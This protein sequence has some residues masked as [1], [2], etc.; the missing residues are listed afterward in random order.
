VILK[1][2]SHADDTNTIIIIFYVKVGLYFVATTVPLAANPLA[3]LLRCN[4]S[5]SLNFFPFIGHVMDDFITLLNTSSRITT[6]VFFIT[7]AG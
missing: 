2:N 3:H 5:F 1:L 6:P 7:M 4:I